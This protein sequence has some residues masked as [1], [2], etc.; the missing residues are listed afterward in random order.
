MDPLAQLLAR[1]EMSQLAERYALAIDCRDLDSLV[2]LFV[3]DVDCG[4]FG[5]GREARRES[6]TSQLRPVG[7]GVMPVANHVIDFDDDAHAHGI[8]YSIAET[9][10]PEGGIRQAI[11]YHDRYELREGRWL[12]VRRKHLLW[13]G[14]VLPY[15]PMDQPPAEWPKSQIGRGTVPECWESWRRFNGEHSE[16]SLAST[17]GLSR[18][19][20]RS[21]H[22]ASPAD[23]NRLTGGATARIGAEEEHAVAALAGGHEPPERCIGRELRLHL[24]G[25]DPPLPGDAFDVCVQQLGGGPTRHD[26]IGADPVGSGLLGGVRVNARAP[27]FDAL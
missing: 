21:G 5:S 19:A 2:A 12:F 7:K 4:H 15:N 16:R 25:L 24:L 9:T 14:V 11:Q 13:Y 17:F 23:A 22:A 27:N 18:P 6:F 10:M 3:T 20:T 26:T 1:D 8:V